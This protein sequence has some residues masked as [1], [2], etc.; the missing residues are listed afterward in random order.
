M[1]GAACVGRRCTE[2]LGVDRGRID[3]VILAQQIVGDLNMF[4]MSE[5]RIVDGMCLKRAGDLGA[6]FSSYLKR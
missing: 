2:S 1:S 6:H 5:R 3:E 4:G